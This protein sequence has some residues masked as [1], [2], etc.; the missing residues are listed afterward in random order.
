MAAFMVSEL[1]PSDDTISKEENHRTSPHP[2][3]LTCWEDA[4]THPFNEAL[5][6]P[7][8]YFIFSSINLRN[9]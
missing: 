2:S 3:F 4:E 7:P 9:T 8:L 5:C 1:G 6:P